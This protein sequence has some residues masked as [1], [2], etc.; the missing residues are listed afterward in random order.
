M[1]RQNASDLIHR[2][3]LIG[4]FVLIISIAFA[5]IFLTYV[6]PQSR[7][8]AP[9]MS[10]SQKNK[11]YESFFRNK[12]E[13]DDSPQRGGLMNN[14]TGASQNQENQGS[15]KSC[16]TLAAKINGVYPYPTSDSACQGAYNYCYLGKTGGGKSIINQGSGSYWNSGNT[17]GKSNTG[18]PAGHP[19][20]NGS[21]CE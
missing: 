1:A 17:S 16:S 14:R 15:L 12:R 5:Y 6:L 8:S 11:C 13:K 4:F 7:A 3:L 21:S 20:W 9:T 10:I 2:I 19:N 18:C